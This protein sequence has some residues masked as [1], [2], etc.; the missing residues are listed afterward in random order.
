M[1]FVLTNI[2]NQKLFICQLAI[3]AGIIPTTTPS[4]DIFIES[5]RSSHIDFQNVKTASDTMK[6]F[7]EKL[8][9]FCRTIF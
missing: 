3:M 8:M 6:V 4:Q 7:I 5:D 1:L 2:F 9:E